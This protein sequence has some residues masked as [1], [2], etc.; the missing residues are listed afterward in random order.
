MKH[1]K[2]MQLMTLIALAQPAYSE[3]KEITSGFGN[4]KCP[5]YRKL[6]QYKED[7]ATTVADKV[8]DWS[9]GY[10]SGRNSEAISRLKAATAENME[11][12]SRNIPTREYIRGYLDNYCK[13]YNSAH[14]WLGLDKIYEESR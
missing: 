12:A 11:A 9:Q 10:L 14:L 13:Q 3:S 2:L 8:I 5:D 1:L 4:M 6:I 7:N